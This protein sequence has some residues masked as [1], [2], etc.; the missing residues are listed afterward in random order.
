MQLFPVGLQKK[1]FLQ[2][3]DVQSSFI[4]E[5]STGHQ[6]QVKTPDEFDVRQ[7]SALHAHKLS[8]MYVLAP[9]DLHMLSNEE[10][11]FIPLQTQVYARLFG[12]EFV[13]HRKQVRTPDVFKV[14]YVLALQEHKLFETR[15]LSPQQV[16][17]QVTTLQKQF[18]I[19]SQVLVTL[20]ETDPTGQV[21]QVRDP[22]ML[23]VQQEL[24]LQTQILL[25][26]VEFGPQAV[27]DLLAG[28]QKLFPEHSQTVQLL[29]A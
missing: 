28:E 3:H 1:L 21:K 25:K 5:I 4:S 26:T 24:E 20:L 15:V 17:K 29:L 6:I 10:Q 22:E 19:Q 11:K 8:A 2:I 14:R 12:I 27:Q 18:P 9:H 7:E 23:P 16:H 13:G